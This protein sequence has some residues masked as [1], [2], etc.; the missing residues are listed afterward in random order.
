M[1]TKILR[2]EIALCEILLSL[3]RIE[4]NKSYEIR[5]NLEF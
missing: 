2:K 5:T 4:A 3:Y 1:R